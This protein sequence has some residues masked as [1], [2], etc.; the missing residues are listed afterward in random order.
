MRVLVNEKELYM[1]IIKLVDF[2]PCKINKDLK[3]P[4]G[5]EDHEVFKW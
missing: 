4:N 1:A 2:K 5:F 3:T